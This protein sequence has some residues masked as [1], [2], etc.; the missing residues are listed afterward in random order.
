MHACIG[1]GPTRC[2]RCDSGRQ[3]DSTNDQGGPV[4]EALKCH[5]Y[6]RL[7]SSRPG[8]TSSWQAVHVHCY[9]RKKRVASVATDNTVPASPE[10]SSAKHP[11]LL[12]LLHPVLAWLQPACACCFTAAAAV[13]AG[14]AAPAVLSCIGGVRRLSCLCCWCDGSQDCCSACK[15]MQVCGATQ[16]T[17]LACSSNNK[18]WPVSMTQ[19]DTRNTR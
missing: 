11:M 3:I 1:W 9:R 7:V 17:Q 16:R 18:R 5:M 2:D 14:P 8:C 13:A 15:A 12:Q 6:C 10:T 4:L 19:Q